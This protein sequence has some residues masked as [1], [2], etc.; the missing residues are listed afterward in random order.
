MDWFQEEAETKFESK[1]S[2]S[3]DS[4]SRIYPY[5]WRL[6]RCEWYG[7]MF[8]FAYKLKKE[9]ERGHCWYA[10]EM[11]MKNNYCVMDRISDWV[12]KPLWHIPV[13]M[14]YL[15]FRCFSRL[16][17]AFFSLCSLRVNWSRT[18]WHLRREKVSYCH[19]DWADWLIWASNIDSLWNTH[20]LTK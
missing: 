4:I 11:I 9:D 1:F 19:V 7:K 10:K 5:L 14:S 18:D 3:I 2:H 12:W 8:L 15:R 20:L 13:K 16:K 17:S 6:W